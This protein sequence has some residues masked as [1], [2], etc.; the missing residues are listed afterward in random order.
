VV[1]D[2][3]QGDTSSSIEEVIDHLY[4]LSPEMF[5]KAR[6]DAAQRLRT[7]GNL[8]GSDLL[9]T[10][11]RPTVAAW[12]IDQLPRR[13]PDLVIELLEAG[14]A[15]RAAQRAA[16]SR[17]GKGD[18]LLKA[19]ERRRLAVASLFEEASMVLREAGREPAVHADAIRSTLEAAS[20]DEATGGLFRSGRLTKE[21]SP[22]AGLG[23][24]TPF[25][26]LTGGRAERRAERDEGEGSPEARAR[27]APR[28]S[29]AEQGLAAAKEA[30]AE[31]LR[32][33]DVAKQDVE[34]LER[35]LRTARSRT[36]R[37]TK[38]AAAAQERV[39]AAERALSRAQAD[40]DPEL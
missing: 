28:V 30:A 25:E 36:E 19:S 2:G 29:K 32:E 35:E 15:L 11:K 6:N 18:D 40:L 27:S 33:V 5:T 4:S 34:R 24:I 8:V 10:L 13:R 14:T 12:S 7:E 17:S 38:A 20:I 9:R 3:G 37:A 39:E 21:V 31:S 26:V 23:D 1:R 22:P 16:L